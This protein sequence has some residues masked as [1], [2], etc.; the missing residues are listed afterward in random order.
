MTDKENFFGTL[1]MVAFGKGYDPKKIFTLEGRQLIK[2]MLKEY[3]NIEIS[4][5]KFLKW[6]KEWVK[7]VESGE[8]LEWE[9]KKREG[10]SDE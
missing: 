2:D 1:N 3:S 9:R 6:S 7:K 5:R 8:P 4:D 10:E